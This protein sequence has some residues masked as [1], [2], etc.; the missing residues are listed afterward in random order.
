ML[1]LVWNNTSQNVQPTQAALASDLCMYTSQ[2]RQVPTNLNALRLHLW[3]M[4]MHRP[5]GSAAC[6]SCTLWSVFC[7]WCNDAAMQT[8]TTLTSRVCHNSLTDH[9]KATQWWL[10]M[11]LQHQYTRRHQVGIRWMTFAHLRLQAQDA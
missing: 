8:L 4:Y 5:I 3:L 6:A 9:C 2:Q 7:T 10:S 11:S 1:H